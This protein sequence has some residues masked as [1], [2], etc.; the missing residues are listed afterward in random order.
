MGRYDFRAQRVLQGAT[1]LLEAKRIPV[2]PPWYDVVSSIPPSERIV[3]P[4]LHRGHLSARQ[5]TPRTHTQAVPPPRSRPKKASRVFQPVQIKYEEDY[6]RKEFFSDHPWELARPRVILENDGRDAQRCDWSRL[7]QPGRALDGESVI[8]RQL[9]L[10]THSGMSKAAAYDQ[11]RKEF[12]AIRHDQDIERRVSREEAL[13][14]GAYFGLSNLEV[15]MVLEDRQYENW[16]A[17]AV[18]EIAAQEQLKGAAYSGTENEDAN[19]SAVLDTGLLG[20][21]IELDDLKGSGVK[22]SRRGQVALG[23][24]AVHP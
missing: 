15:G 24:A 2:S 23:G 18:K 10:I 13:A 3:R 4:A 12:Y 8:Q 16:K 9:Y 6:L 20:E 21:N 19:S 17:W 14:T 1:R 22:G 11:A 5:T 7:Q